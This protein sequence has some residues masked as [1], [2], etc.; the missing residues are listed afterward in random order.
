MMVELD[1]RQ[2][3]AMARKHKRE[4]QESTSEKDEPDLSYEDIRRIG[5][6]RGVAKACARYV[7][8]F[9]LD[10]V[11]FMETVIDSYHNRIREQESEE[12]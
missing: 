8:Q 1:D 2:I 11:R 5:L 7:E 10:P 4:S 3:K 6:A 9:D 12:D